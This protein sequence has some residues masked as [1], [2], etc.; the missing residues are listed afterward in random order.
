M[1][2]VYTSCHDDLYWNYYSPIQQKTLSHLN[3]NFWNAL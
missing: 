1:Y 2:V 3:K